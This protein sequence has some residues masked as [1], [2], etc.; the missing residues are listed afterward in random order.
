[1]TQGAAVGYVVS[2]RLYSLLP[3]NIIELYRAKWYNTRNNYL[4]VCRLKRLYK[5]D[6][7][8]KFAN[9]FVRVGVDDHR[10]DEHKRL[11]VHSSAALIPGEL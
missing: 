5:S 7:V 6:L 1:M 11:F 3:M 10:K 9:L 4:L 8:Q 2:L